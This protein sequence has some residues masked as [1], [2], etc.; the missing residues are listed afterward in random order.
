MFWEYFDHIAI[1]LA[2]V[3]P[4]ISVWSAMVNRFKKQDVDR[5]T[6]LAGMER[7]IISRL[8]LSDDKV[9]LH[10][11]QNLRRFYRID[12]ALYK[13][14]LIARPTDENGGNEN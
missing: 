13:A 8:D 7:R 12:M 1:F 2:A 3:V 10:H 4:V 14:G 9:E 5:E 6:R 11:T